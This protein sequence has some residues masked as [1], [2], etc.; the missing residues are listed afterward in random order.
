ME[1]MMKGVCIISGGLDS[2]VVAYAM[3]NH[4]GIDIDLDLITF[5]YGQKHVKEIDYARQIAKDLNCSWTLIDLKLPNNILNHSSLTGSKEIPEGHYAEE[6]MR[7]TVVPN[8]NTIM[9][10][11]AWSYACSVKADLLGCGAHAGDHYIYPDCRP[12]YF[13][14]LEKAFKLGTE[15]CGGDDLGF[16]IP[17]LNETKK[18]V[19]AIGNRFGVPFEKTWTCYKG[20][21]LPCGKCGSCDER[22]NAFKEL[23][24]IDPVRYANV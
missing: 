5:N 21:E 10:S 15:G 22:I 19:V 3:K 7:S 4:L 13:E 1:T 12:K 16:Y 20:Q 14:T 18:G 23:G 2:C 11:V 9:L 8:R 17:L 24:L 6:S